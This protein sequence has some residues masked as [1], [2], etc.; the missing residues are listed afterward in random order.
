M[1]R[2]ASRW[3]HS[4]EFLLR[5]AARRGSQTYSISH[6]IVPGLEPLLDLGV[7]GGAMCALLQRLLEGAWGA[8]GGET[9]E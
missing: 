5:G 6:L 9:W 1:H 8:E 2:G 3:S 7:D 4:I